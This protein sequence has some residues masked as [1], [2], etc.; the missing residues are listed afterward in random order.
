MRRHDLYKPDWSCPVSCLSFGENWKTEYPDVFFCHGCDLLEDAVNNGAKRAHWQQ[1]KYMAQ[2]VTPTYRIR[3]Q[4]K[5]NTGLISRHQV[6]QASQEKQVLN[7]ISKNQGER[8]TDF[9]YEKCLLTEE[10]LQEETT[11]RGTTKFA[12][13]CTE[14]KNAFAQPGQRNTRIEHHRTLF[15][16]SFTSGIVP[17]WKFHQE[18]KGAFRVHQITQ[19]QESCSRRK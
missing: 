16:Y 9:F 4:Q 15:C 7:M 5:G 3:Q 1:K 11:P 2:L 10:P 8:M 13:D 14:C 17:C 18:G 6:L 19:N 12:G